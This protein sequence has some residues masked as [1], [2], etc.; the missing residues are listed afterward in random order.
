MADDDEWRGAWRKPG[1]L[2]SSSRTQSVV[3]GTLSA[4]EA[5]EVA[6]SS[7]QAAVK[8]RLLRPPARLLM[9]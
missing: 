8:L 6:E 9:G 3:A 2:A 7:Q 1:V 5:P 4:L